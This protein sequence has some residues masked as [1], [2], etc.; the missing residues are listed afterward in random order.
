MELPVRTLTNLARNALTSD[1]RGWLSLT[2]MSKQY[3]D[4]LDRQLQELKK[5]QQIL[6]PSS[7]SI[8]VARKVEYVDGPGSRKNPGE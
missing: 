3:Q 6:E 5:W 1:L 8:Q 7:G 2:A 4:D